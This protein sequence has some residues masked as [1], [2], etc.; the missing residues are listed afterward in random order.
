VFTRDAIRQ[1]Q[2]RNRRLDTGRIAPDDE[3]LDVLADEAAER[4]RAAQC[5]QLR[6][7]LANLR[8]DIEARRAEVEQASGE[9]I[10]LSQKAETLDRRRDLQLAITALSE[11]VP[12]IRVLRGA[13]G[14]RAALRAFVRG[15]GAETGTLST[16]AAEAGDLANRFDLGIRNLRFALDELE[17]RQDE[18]RRL[19]D[20]QSRLDCS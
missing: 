4:E 14:I 12:A 1:A 9:V 2:R 6:I 11:T 19:I 7:D 15:V 3:M 10:A 13:Q 8:I 5:T 20:R 16:R 17:G 18:R